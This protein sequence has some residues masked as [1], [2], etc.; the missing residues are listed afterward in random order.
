MGLVTFCT[1]VSDFSLNGTGV[2]SN[3]LEIKLHHL[4]SLKDK[5]V[6]EIQVQHGEA[7]CGLCMKKKCYRGIPVGLNLFTVIIFSSSEDNRSEAYILNAP[8]HQY[9]ICLG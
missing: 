7:F 8:I 3:V 9:P 5:E 4:N 2:I 6:N 1:F